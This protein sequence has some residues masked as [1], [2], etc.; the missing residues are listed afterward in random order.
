M[1][2][3]SQGV[4]E[5]IGSQAALPIQMTGGTYGPTWS[6]V[7]NWTRTW[8]AHLVTDNRFSYSLI[9]IDDTV[10]DWSGQLG[11]DG[12]SKFGIPG[13]QPISGLSSF[14]IGQGLTGIGAR[15]TIATTR[16]NKFQFQSNFTFQ[17]G[18]HLLKFG[19]HLLR[20]RQNRYYAGNNGALGSFMYNGGYSGV[21]IGD[22]LLDTLA[23]RAAARS[24]ALGPSPMAQHRF[25]PG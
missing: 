22:F 20:M 8:S 23:T 18:A 14:T 21:D 7:T 4:Y 12:N 16:D 9:G 1:F 13:G 3:Y 2:R 25:R 11:A 5:T 15:A 10:I 6:A 19:V 17:T 24:A